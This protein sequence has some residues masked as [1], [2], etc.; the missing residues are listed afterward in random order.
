MRRL[1]FAALFFCAPA[2]PGGCRRP[3]VRRRRC[4]EELNGWPENEY[5]ALVPQ[6][7]NGT[8][9]W[10]LWY[11]EQGVYA[12]FLTGITAPRASSMCRLAAGGV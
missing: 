11:E 6:P 4:R 2:P 3:A 7:E 12:V 9:A 5:T 1:L 10:A 8:P